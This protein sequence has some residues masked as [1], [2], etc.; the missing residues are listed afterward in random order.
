MFISPLF[1]SICLP[2][3]IAEFSS[4]LSVL[5]F[6]LPFMDVGVTTEAEWKDPFVCSIRKALPQLNSPSAMNILISADMVIQRLESSNSLS[7]NSIHFSEDPFKLVSC[8]SWYNLEYSAQ[9]DIS[10]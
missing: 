3:N 5:H 7:W 9:P 4:A 10:P 1:D 2:L 6:L 8:T